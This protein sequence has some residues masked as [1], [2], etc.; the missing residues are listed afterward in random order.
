MGRAR[1]DAK[2][3]EAVGARLGDAV[4]DPA[5]W[6][7]ILEELSGALDTTGAALLQADVRTADIP[8]TASVGQLL[9]TYFKDGWHVRDARAARGVPLLLGG[10]CVVTDHD[11]FSP[12]EMARSP[13]HQECLRPLG[14]QWFA[15]VGFWA[16]SALW[17]LSLQRTIRQGPFEVDGGGGGLRLH[18]CPAG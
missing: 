6:P 8:R 17:G 10:K 4:V 1:L 16:G 9:S 5:N 2:K 7:V 11:L 12:E 14:F 13:F 3:L 18:R 15:A